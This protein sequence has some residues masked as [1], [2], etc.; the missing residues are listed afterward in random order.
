MEDAGD[1]ADEYDYENEADKNILGKEIP[2][3]FFDLFLL[4][5]Y[6]LSK[7]GL[8]WKFLNYRNF[9]SSNLHNRNVIGRRRKDNFF[10]II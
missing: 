7:S 2:Y 10:F 3:V 5:H 6:T 9:N 8:D 4:C 1:Y